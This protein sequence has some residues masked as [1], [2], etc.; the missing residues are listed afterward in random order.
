MLDQISSFVC[1]VVL[2]TLPC[3]AGNISGINNFDQ[4]DAHVYRGAQP[5]GDG[6]RYLASIGMKTV[7]DLQESGKRA[8]AEERLVTDL[9]MAYLNVPMTGLTPPTEAELLK[10]LPV[11]ENATAGPVFVHCWRG[12]DR[13]G[14][15]IAA[16]HIDHHHWD[17][18]QALKDAKSHSM[19]SSQHP[20]QNFI[21]NFRPLMV[22][23]KSAAEAGTSATTSVTMAPA[24]VR[25]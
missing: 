2:G 4:V 24:S 1:L 18:T 17:N 23:V 21:K 13:T 10:I 3:V 16:Y 12:A 14:A 5:T 11:L 9:G 15:V 8:K 7:I 22:E 19:G 20:R 25:E 6:F